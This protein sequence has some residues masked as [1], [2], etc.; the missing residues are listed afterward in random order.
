MDGGATTIISG[1]ITLTTAFGSILLKDHLDQRREERRSAPPLPAAPRPTAA[2]LPLP[3]ERPSAS[4]EPTA[5]ARARRR[6]LWR[7]IAR[8]VVTVA[9]GFGLGDA[10][11]HTMG[12]ESGLWTVAVIVLAA[13]VLLVFFA[14]Q[15]NRSL[16]GYQLAVLTLWSAF[17]V[18]VSYRSG[19]IR[20]G[21][22]T[23]FLIF[24]GS[25]AILGLIVFGLTR[26]RSGRVAG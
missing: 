10:M 14:R 23:V 22:P 19:Y 8:A 15:A 11:G 7:S 18:G 5:P 24:W 20:D 9:F 17:M 1:V 2:A 4:A 16:L 26:R 3:V 12:D 13:L 21:T 25:S 6:S